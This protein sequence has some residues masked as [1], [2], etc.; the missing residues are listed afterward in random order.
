MTRYFW[1]WIRRV[2]IYRILHVDD[3]PHRIAM[4]VAVGLFVGAS[5]L[6]GLHML[7][8]LMLGTLVKANRAVC[9]VAVWVSNPATFL[10]IISFNWVVGQAV[11]PRSPLQNP[12]EVKL[13]LSQV[14]GATEGIS[15]FVSHVFSVKF[16]A[17]LLQLFWE[18]GAELWIG[19]LLVGVVA[20]AAG[21]FLTRRAVIW[22]RILRRLRRERLARRTEAEPGPGR[23]AEDLLDAEEINAEPDHL[24]EAPRSSPK[25]VKA[26]ASS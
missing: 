7:L 8:A 9:L 18:L 5:P 22:R 19:S 17:A 21:Y 26:G 2:V 3:T 15:A 6:I 11:W 13:R 24:G 14:L 20:A 25:L 1:R 16:W 23:A 4:G 10:P 12:V